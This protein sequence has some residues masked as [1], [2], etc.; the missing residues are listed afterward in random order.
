M[1]LIVRQIT[2]QDL[3]LSAKRVFWMVHDTNV[4]ISVA[5]LGTEFVPQIKCVLR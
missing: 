3:V 5:I 4:L 2:P 1:E